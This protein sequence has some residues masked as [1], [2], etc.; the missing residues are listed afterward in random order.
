MSLL[1]QTEVQVV[2]LKIVSVTV[3]D[4]II[5]IIGLVSVATTDS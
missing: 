3:S 4:V 1:S 5:V 2:W